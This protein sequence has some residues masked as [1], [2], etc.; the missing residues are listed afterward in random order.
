MFGWKNNAWIPDFTGT[1][2]ITQKN[3]DITNFD[4]SID[5]TAG[6]SSGKGNKDVDAPKTLEDAIKRFLA[7]NLTYDEFFKLLTNDFKQ[8]VKSI[9]QDDINGDDGTLDISFATT[10]GKQYKLSCATKAAKSS[11]DYNTI[12][13]YTSSD[14]KDKYGFD[15]EII[16]KYFDCVGYINDNQEYF[17][18]KSE[19]IDGKTFKNPQELL[20][21]LYGRAMDDLMISNFLGDKA[22]TI[23]GDAEVTDENWADYD[24]NVE[25]IYAT[26]VE[27]EAARQEAFNKF[28]ED[29]VSGKIA[30]CDVK[31]LLDAIMG[32]GKQSSAIIF[33]RLENSQVWKLEFK[34]NGKSYKLHCGYESVRL[35]QKTI[36]D[37]N[38]IRALALKLQEAGYDYT[39]FFEPVAWENDVPI[40]YKL[41]DGVD[42]SILETLE[43]FAKNDKLSFYFNPYKSDEA[44]NPDSTGSDDTGIKNPY[45]YTILEGYKPIPVDWVANISIKD[46][47]TDGIKD[48]LNPK[49]SFNVA[50]EFFHYSNFTEFAENYC[51]GT[52]KVFIRNDAIVS[53]ENSNINI[54]EKLKEYFISLVKDLGFDINKVANL[55]D[56]VMSDLMN[57]LHNANTKTC[58][59][60]DIFDKFNKILDKKFGLT[61]AT[62]EEISKAMRSSGYKDFANEFGKDGVFVDGNGTVANE[63]G[64]DITEKLFEYFLN[65]TSDL[66]QV[67][68]ERLKEMFYGILDSFEGSYYEMKDFFNMIESGIKSYFENNNETNPD[69]GDNTDNTTPPT[70]NPE[71]GDNTV[72]DE[73]VVPPVE[74]DSVEDSEGSIP[75]VTGSDVNEYLTFDSFKNYNKST[76]SKGQTINLSD[77][78]TVSLELNS[79]GNAKIYTN[80][81]S[82]RDDVDK[83]FVE[84][85]IENAKNIPE[86]AGYSDDEL[87]TLCADIL[88]DVVQDY[89]KQGLYTCTMEELFKAFTT[90]LQNKIN[91]GKV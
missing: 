11:T 90:K 28:L 70:T 40:A 85:F 46:L 91:N 76:T 84:W 78:K 55:F 20:D 30:Q 79:K 62:D 2:Y 38:T 74:D 66:P 49:E 33:E 5:P 27:Q 48:S 12:K 73:P 37:G 86:L 63:N 8:Q 34:F 68:A 7:G 35:E 71:E 21:Y 82:I 42:A 50:N 23:Y 22:L 31:T 59:L 77:N 26:D 65:L 89:N 53:A 1:S 3:N 9:S 54:T 57:E 36:Y 75:S 41:K 14:L 52:E 18:L 60:K 56:E 16:A 13:Y 58:S 44:V 17:V 69:T 32:Y 88:K 47:Q 61:P 29:F 15:K 51:E 45:G 39:K 6:G 83:V 43:T 81:G 87:R 25:G 19:E 24:Q 10:D 72:D 67:D 64:E 80:D 4:P